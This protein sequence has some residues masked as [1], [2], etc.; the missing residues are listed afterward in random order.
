MKDVRYLLSR[1]RKIEYRSTTDFCEIYKPFPFNKYQRERY[2]P[3]YCFSC[4]IKK[5]VH[6]AQNFAK[7]NIICLVVVLGTV[8]PRRLIDEFD[9][10]ILILSKADFTKEDKNAYDEFLKLKTRLFSRGLLKKNGDLVDDDYMFYDDVENKHRY[11]EIKNMFAEISADPVYTAYDK[12]E[13]PFV[14]KVD[15]LDKYSKKI[16][17]MGV[18]SIGINEAALSKTYTQKAVQLAVECQSKDGKGLTKPKTNDPIIK[19]IQNEVNRRIKEDGYFDLYDI[20]CKVSEPPFGL[21]NYAYSAYII[22]FAFCFGGLTNKQIEALVM[23]K[24][25]LS[26]RKIAD[27]MGVTKTA[28]LQHIHSFMEKIHYNELSVFDGCGS[29]NFVDNTIA[30]CVWYTLQSLENNPKRRKRFIVYIRDDSERAVVKL[31]SNLFDIREDT[32]VI[33]QIVRSKSKLEEITRMPICKFNNDVFNLLDSEKLYS[34]SERD[35]LIEKIGDVD[36]N[37]L[38]LY[39]EFSERMIEKYDLNKVLSS[40]ASWVWSLKTID[41]YINGNVGCQLK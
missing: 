34:R 2:L 11:I 7:P 37:F 9:G 41:R 13:E 31:L 17:P 26:Q 36:E 39:K 32:D 25:G 22:T 3:F 1:D 30:M 40:S 8:D 6:Y 18:E 15:R 5:T 35:T 38:N 20:I 4:N 27:K 16:F 10:N 19:Y 33:N 23:Y 28:A 24:D 21:G 12:S 14:M 29:F